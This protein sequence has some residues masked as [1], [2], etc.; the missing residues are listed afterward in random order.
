MLATVPW[1]EVVEEGVGV[2]LIPVVLIL[3]VPTRTP[4]AMD[5]RVDSLDLSSLHSLVVH[6]VIMDVMAHPH[7]DTMEDKVT[8]ALALAVVEAE[9]AIMP[10]VVVM[11][12][13]II[14]D[15]IMVDR[16][17]PDMSIE[18]L[19]RHRE[20]RDMKIMD[21][22]LRRHLQDFQTDPIITG[23][24][25]LPHLLLVGI[26][27]HL[28]HL[29]S[30]IGDLAQEV[31]VVRPLEDMVSIIVV[32]TIPHLLL[33]AADKVCI[34]A[35]MIMAL[36]GITI[37]ETG[38]DTK[39][40]GLVMIIVL[41]AFKDHIGSSSPSMIIINSDSNTVKVKVMVMGMGDDILS[42]TT[43]SSLRA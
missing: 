32:V 30:N 17:L 41:R 19:L 28:H 43:R 36:V 40:L 15:I 23:I 34:I 11:G 37:T 16:L 12:D 10:G 38:T 9:E 20:Y 5:L 2:T 33:A 1:D 26:K 29:R 21:H 31:L 14:L 8:M 4:M 3:V 18:V 25:A 42:S 6:L 13:T 22:L 24:M 7:L 35:T 27:D 39:A